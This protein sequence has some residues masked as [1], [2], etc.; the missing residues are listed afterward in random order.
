M[1]PTINR[2]AV[3]IVDGSQSHDLIRSLNEQK[4]R[5]TR[6][7]ATGGFLHDSLVTLFV[8]TSARRL[9]QLFALLREKCP[10][11]TRYVPMGVEM[12]IAPGPPSMIEVYVGGATVFILP[13]EQFRY[14]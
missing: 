14:L 12:A 4:F 3:I 8:G 13:V 10:R 7:S 2:L 1:E 6:V 11:H 5:V 9:P